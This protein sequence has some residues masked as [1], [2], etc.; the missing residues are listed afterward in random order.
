MAKNKRPISVIDSGLGGISVLGHLLEELPSEDFVYFG[1]TANAPYGSKTT[2]E[3]LT[4]TL[5]NIKM[6]E[7]EYYAKA[8]V[9][10]CNTAT[11]AAAEKCREIYSHMPIIGI[12]PA[13]KP[14]VTLSGKEAPRVLVMAT[15]LTLSQ[16]K[17]VHLA[18][19]YNPNADLIP[20][21]CP[22][23]SQVIESG[24]DEKAV[25]TLLDKLFEGVECHN[26]DAV[27]LGCT[28][29]P[30]IKEYIA[31][32]FPKAVIY[33]GGLGTALQTKRR[34]AEAGLIE[35]DKKA[36]KLTIINSA[37]NTEFASLAN[38]YLRKI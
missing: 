37:G 24:G 2:E 20:L 18:E 16:E 19:K 33:D 36:G 29:Y 30:L 31:K 5:D 27:V 4:L 7:D 17:F 25:V 3:V 15:P 12:E 22:G 26:I 14:A 13:I 23:L 8:V 32:Y 38:K 9:I 10:A 1:D 34:L 35:A 21:P 6:L 28:H 11:G